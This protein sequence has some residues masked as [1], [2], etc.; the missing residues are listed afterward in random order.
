M[1]ELHRFEDLEPYVDFIDEQTIAGR[2]LAEH[3]AK[4]QYLYLREQQPWVVAFSGGKDSTA[5][6]TL[7]YFALLGLSP[8][9][10]S[11][12]VYV[13]FCDT[14]AEVPYY[15]K[16][17]MQVLNGV[18]SNAAQLGLPI[19]V[20]IISPKP[21]DTFWS[22]LLGRGY[23]APNL[24]VNRW[25]TER[26]K[27]QPFRDFA[28]V[29]FAKGEYPIV[30]I[31]S[32]SAES[33]NREAIIE[34]YHAGDKFFDESDPVYRRYAAIKDWSVQEV[35]KL[36]GQR[37]A[38]GQYEDLKPWENPWGG[39]NISLVEMYDSTN[40]ASGECP[41]VETANSPGCGK[42]RFGCWSCTVV[43]KD[44]A[45]DGLIANGET[46][47]QPLAE[48]RNFLHSTTEVEAKQRYRQDRRRDGKVSLKPGTQDEVETEFIQGPYYLH[49]RKEW[50]KQLLQM[51]KDLRDAGHSI[52]LITEAELHEIR[53]QW[54]HDPL[55]PD[56]QDELPQIYR[57]VY[58]DHDIIFP[59]DDGSRFSQN[60]VSLIDTLA[61][62]HGT[63]SNLVKKL[64]ALETSLQGMGKRKGLFQRLDKVLAQDWGSLDDAKAK[65][66]SEKALYRALTASVQ[67]I[68]SELQDIHVMLEKDL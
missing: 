62:Q 15:L 47:L 35:W 48:F 32:R 65:K 13:V 8:A 1:Y 6:L 55:T 27:L 14:L 4:L 21:E 17:V 31:G 22:R 43:T 18:R 10:R 68:E 50:L 38:H 28:L 11:N 25:C 5:I 33:S 67:Q 44:K 39:T 54:R 59:V 9:Q 16:K 46:W 23:P 52:R 19:E 30:V 26:I 60:E 24:K 45:I 20:K 12:K 3:V 61:Q 56:W 41:L 64:L 53:Y 34:K 58:G 40:A 57:E 66:E 63:D 42:S 36:L 51:E 37:I 49:Y 7:M 2:P 29:E